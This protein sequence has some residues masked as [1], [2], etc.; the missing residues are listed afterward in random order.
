MATINKQAEKWMSKASFDALDKSTIPVGTEI[1]IVGDIQESDLSPDLINKINNAGG[2]LWKLTNTSGGWCAFTFYV[3]TNASTIEELANDIVNRP[4]IVGT[5]YATEEEW[6]NES[7]G[8]HIL[9]A[10]SISVSSNSFTIRAFSYSAYL[11]G[12]TISSHT[13]YDNSNAT[14]SVEKIY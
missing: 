8:F 2:H 9:K 7:V 11:M 6:G 3:N 1:N 14:F 5:F 4:A 13:G 10:K 12:T